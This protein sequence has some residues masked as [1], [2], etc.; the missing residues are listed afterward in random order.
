MLLELVF[1]QLCCA[2]PDPLVE[3]S[4]ALV[5]ALALQRRPLKKQ[6]HHNNGN[7]AWACVAVAIGGHGR[8]VACEMVRG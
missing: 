2:L 6:K 4:H 5:L 1:E 8:N 7:R 3:L